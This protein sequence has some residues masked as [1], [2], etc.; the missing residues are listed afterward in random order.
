VQ[1]P[2]LTA[3]LAALAGRWT[4]LVAGITGALLAFVAA[5][6]VLYVD[7]T[8]S[9]AVG[10]EE[11][12]YC[13]QLVPPSL[14]PAFVSGVQAAAIRDA[15][16]RIGP[17]YGF[18][19]VVFAAY[20]TGGE[21]D[22]NGFPPPVRFGYRDGALDHLRVVE[23]GGRNGVWV[24]D[25]VAAATRTRIGQVAQRPQLPPVSAIYRQLHNPLPGWWCSEQGDVITPS[26]AGD[27][28]K[29][30]VVFLPDLSSLAGYGPVLDVSVRFPVAHLPRTVAEAQDLQRRG[31]A[32]LA[33]LRRALAEQG[34]G[35]TGG[36]QRFAQPLRAATAARHNVLVSVLPLT[37][38]SLLV[39]LAGVAALGAQYVQ[40]RRSE[41]WLLWTR[42]SAP[43][44]LGGRAVLEL[45]APLALG[46]AAGLLLARLTLGWYA[47]DTALDPGTTARAA[48]VAGAV[49]TVALLSLAGT[50]SWR[51]HRSFQAVRIPGLGRWRWLRRVPW[52]LAT[53]A[54][55]VVAWS[56]LAHGLVHV[57]FG[58]A[59]SAVIDPMAL[60]FPLLVVLTVAGVVV[61]LL[62]S[63]L[64]GSRRRAWWWAPAIQ[65]AVR[66]LAAAADA[67]GGIVLV[68]VL[69]IG[70]LTVGHGVAG[71]ERSAL[72]AKS[73]TLVGAN[74]AVQIGTTAVQDR[75]PL[76]DAVRGN[77]TVVG[78]DVGLGRDQ[79]MLVDPA[80]FARAAWIDRGQADRVRHLLDLL[81]TPAAGGAVPA[82]R[83][84][85]ARDGVVRLP[86]VAPFAP[87][88]TVADFPG[89]RGNVGYVV[90]ASAVSEPRM[91]N[92][93]YLWST[94]D[95]A[96]VTGALD[97]AG[98]SFTDAASVDRALD[99]LPFYTVAW[100]FGFI[101]ALG[102]VLAIVAA[103]SLLLAVETRRRQNALS[104]ALA[105][106]MG[107]RPRTLV[108]S[109]CAELGA[110]ALLVLVAGG[111]VG[112]VGAG[113]SAPRLDPA[114]W[115]PPAP[116]VPLLAPLLLT[117]VAGA[118][119][120][121][122]VA[123]RIAVRS[124]RTARVAELIRG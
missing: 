85:T 23:G 68:G 31:D 121:V 109:H 66:R 79:V 28:V 24:P 114:P 52:E 116:A 111:G 41:L 37:A 106:R 75:M 4:A 99:A 69:A 30:P 98:I 101:Q 82:V 55:S 53:A 60:A 70:T 20:T 104:G 61:R 59:A 115:L 14:E 8:G 13:A 1:L 38:V 77:S 56:R 67:V 22:I 65:L 107:L 2:W 21:M 108:G 64:A 123:A 117:T 105:G 71:S 44:A 110:V 5:A 7:A 118:V 94:A 43:W 19:Q 102:V 80:T 83:V 12:Q 51:V 45:A 16:H 103:A 40:R 120:V 34:I 36:L 112:L 42:G 90:P 18:D 88:A 10:Y 62:R 49:L 96:T 100:T 87:V 72:L 57:N 84:G 93:W 35:A 76:P 95:L 17:R 63:A 74:S 50:V 11:G 58:V 25:N 92:S 27:R 97:R 48:L 54:L 3:P 6:G 29:P 9:A 122:G 86:D 89:M 15:A 39:G 113:V 78:F 124:V 91:M 26:M 119:L 73:A 32:M 81:A 47:P 46:E 33:A